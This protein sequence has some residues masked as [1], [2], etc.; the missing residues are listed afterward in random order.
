[1]KGF[2]NLLVICS[3]GMANATVVN[4]RTPHNENSQIRTQSILIASIEAKVQE[5]IQSGFNAIA[6]GDEYGISNLKERNLDADQKYRIYTMA[7]VSFEKALQLN[8]QSTDANYGMGIALFRLYFLDEYMIDTWLE[9]PDIDTVIDYLSRARKLDANNPDLSFELGRALLEAGDLKRSLNYSQE[10]LTLQTDEPWRALANI[11]MVY[12]NMMQQNPAQGE[13]Y[14]AQAQAAWKESISLV[15]P[16]KEYIS[17]LTYQWL[18]EMH[19][20]AAVEFGYDGASESEAQSYR[21]KAEELY[22][23]SPEQIAIREAEQQNQLQ[24]VR[25]NEAAIQE[26]NRVE[27]WQQRPCT[28]DP[29]GG[30]FTRHMCVEGYLDPNDPRGA[31][32]PM[33]SDW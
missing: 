33:P 16:E 8:P 9:I 10:A 3:L 29:S 14:F 30:A 2:F 21:E 31:D 4:A 24:Q 32:Q 28:P 5:H 19:Q 13:P 25:D 17:F 15:P 18:A 6:E 11:G 1:M 12:Y 20:M 22:Q 26:S 7:T 23:Q 27:S